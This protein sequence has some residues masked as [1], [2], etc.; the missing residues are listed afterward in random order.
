MLNSFTN[1]ITATIPKLN[2][3]SMAGGIIG[4]AVWA[5]GGWD[6][7][8]K[9]LFIFAVIDYLTGTIRALKMG[10][11]CSKDG[12]I[13]IVK[14]IFMFVIVAIAHGLDEVAGVNVMRSAV[15]IAYCVNETASILENFEGMG[16]ASVIP[17]PLRKG[18][19]V[20]KEK[21]ESEDIKIDKN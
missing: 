15:I 21:I 20:L 11:L 18:I 19:K 17:M 8:L 14:K 12:F 1:F 13:G 2:G 5:L 7:P 16:I 3:V 9:W 4:G 10:K 6:T